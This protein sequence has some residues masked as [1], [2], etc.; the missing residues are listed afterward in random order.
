MEML[1]PHWFQV[2]EVLFPHLQEKIGPLGSNHER[3]VRIIEF[4]GVR[5]FIGKI[6]CRHSGGRPCDDRIEIA[7][8]FLA[9]HV[10][11]L[12]TTRAVIDRLH[13]DEVLRRLCGWERKGHIPSESK[14]SRVFKE[15]SKM[16]AIETL[17]DR[18]V[19]RYHGDRIIGHVRRDATEI[20]AREKAIKKP[21]LADKEAAREKARC[22]WSGIK[23]RSAWKNNLLNPLKKCWLTCQLV[24]ILAQKSTARGIKSVGRGTNC[25]LTRLMGTSPLAPS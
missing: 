12:P 17:L 25:I 8:A 9:K 5:A 3:L 22:G 23:S 7:I 10:F 14:F 2:Q 15:F 21:K 24:A 11:N 18:V 4:S 6:Y 20:D 16:K 19:A 13:C 1:S